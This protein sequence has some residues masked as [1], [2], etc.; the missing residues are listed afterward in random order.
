MYKA[1]RVNGHLCRSSD[2]VIRN[3]R[4]PVDSIP[5]ELWG[6]LR[7]VV[8]AAVDAAEIASPAGALSAMRIA[9]RYGAWAD[10]QGR[11]LR[12]GALDLNTDDI[13]RFCAL[14]G[15]RLSSSSV[16]TVRSTLRRLSGTGQRGPTPPG[17]AMEPISRHMTAPYS[18]EEMAGFRGCVSVQSTARRRRTLT[19][20]LGLCAGAGLRVTEMMSVTA[21]DLRYKVNDPRLCIIKLPDRTVPVLLEYVDPLRDVARRHLTGPL[22][23]LG[24]S[25]GKDPLAQARKGL[26]IPDRLPALT[27]SRLRTTWMADV[28]RRVRISEFEVMAGTVSAKSLEAVAPH[29]PIRDDYLEHGAGA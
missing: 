21:D 26:E 1:M 13:Q 20:M 14:E 10:E 6:R 22:L 23:G 3:Y 2:E 25:R 4:P 24:S 7:P 5:A 16:S 17:Q 18:P 8:S 28:L 11:R 29:V 9:A 19:V 15:A 27:M 12:D